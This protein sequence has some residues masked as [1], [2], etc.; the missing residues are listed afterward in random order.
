MS[1]A[2]SQKPQQKVEDHVVESLSLR[3]NLSSFV[4]CLHL[5]DLNTLKDWPVITVRTLSTKTTQQ[6][7]QLR[8]RAVEWS[9]YRLLELYDPQTTKD[10]SSGGR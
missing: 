1:A 8:I 10:V 7:L 3:S 4:H 5:L 9:L 6:N 2:N